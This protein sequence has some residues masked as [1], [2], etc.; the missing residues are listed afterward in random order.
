MSRNPEQIRAS[1]TPSIE[2]ST[3]IQMVAFSSETSSNN[4]FTKENLKNMFKEDIHRVGMTLTT[5]AKTNVLEANAMPGSRH[6]LD[7][8]II[9]GNSL[10]ELRK[11]R[12][13]RKHKLTKEKEAPGLNLRANLSNLGRS[14][15]QLLADLL[16]DENLL[17]PTRDMSEKSY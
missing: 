14:L 1:T 10:Q 13:L 11:L 16:E 2:V 17:I 7:V 12:K 3:T 8:K 5:K 15:I 9:R 4:W 6:Y